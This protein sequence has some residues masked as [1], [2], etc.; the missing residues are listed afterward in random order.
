MFQI[1]RNL[2]YF[3]VKR[4]GMATQDRKKQKILLTGAT[5]FLGRHLL[6][7][8]LDRGYDVRALVRNAATRHMDLPPE[9][10]VL[11]GDV[12]D[13]LLLEKGVE[14]AHAVVHA[15]AIV[16]FWRRDRRMLQEVNVEGTARVVNACLEAGVPLVHVSSIAALGQGSESDSP[17]A[18]I[19]ERSEWQPGEK[20]SFYAKSKHLAE[21]EVYRGIAEGLTA[22]FVNP[23]VI[24]G[25]SHDWKS[26]TSKMFSIV[27]RGLSF[28]NP[29]STGF[30][31]VQ[32]VATAI[33]LIL[34]KKD[35]PNGSKFLLNAENL[36]FQ[37]LFSGIAS[38]LNKP[39]PRWKLPMAPTMWV[40][41]LSEGISLLTG[42]APIVTRETM[43]SGFEARRFDGSSI[44]SLGLRYTPMD[45]VIRQAA[46]AYL[47]TKAK[48]A[49]PPVPA[50]S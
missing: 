21:R 8:L 11:D 46:E 39:A 37:E 27:D 14:G 29:G 36:S 24:L 15:A 22:Y 18:L 25:P 1:A 12:S 47:A 42:K 16:S 23:S 17:G 31:G 35:L 10:E 19:S 48:E 6:R 49:E 34:A 4:S 9:V 20:R 13:I 40:A 5:G 33:C 44:L 41:T 50:A 2:A 38:A 26:G 45:M 3:A 30:V 7:A 28:Y 32:D 43:K